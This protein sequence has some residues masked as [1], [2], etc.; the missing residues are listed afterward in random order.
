[1]KYRIKELRKAQGITQE[2]LARRAGVSRVSLSGYEGENAV[3]VKADTLERIAAVLGV[4]VGDL[5]DEERRPEAMTTRELVQELRQREGV[6]TRTAE[7]YR[8]LEIK[9]NGPAIVLVITD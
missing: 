9:V 4:R 5:I 3:S 8:D 7:P 6:E 2:V 1:M